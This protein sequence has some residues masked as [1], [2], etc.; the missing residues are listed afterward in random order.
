LTVFVGSSKKARILALPVIAFSSRMHYDSL[1]HYCIGTQGWRGAG[2]SQQNA[3][4]Q[5]PTTLELLDNAAG[6]AAPRLARRPAPII[7][8]ASV[9]NQRSA[10][11]TE[12]RVRARAEGDGG[13]EDLRTQHARTWHEL[14]RHVARMRAVFNQVTMLVADSEMATSGL[15]LSRGVALSSL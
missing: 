8:D 14:V 9:K 1:V 4:T 5:K 2:S 15:E 7:V 11:R 3:M 13:I 12:E 10:I 6:E